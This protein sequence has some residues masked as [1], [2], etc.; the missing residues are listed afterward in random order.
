MRL[1]RVIAELHLHLGILLE[2]CLDCRLQRLPHADLAVVLN[3]AVAS[4]VLISLRQVVRRL[5][6]AALDVN[7]SLIF[8][9]RVL[10]SDLH[11][12]ICI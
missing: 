7:L 11:R 3:L 10:A 6:I 12:A 8:A 4:A 2:D 9:F 5:L 1:R